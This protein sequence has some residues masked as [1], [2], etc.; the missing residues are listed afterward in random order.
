M[1]KLMHL[2]EEKTMSSNF[3]FLKEKVEYKL[4]A[5]AAIDAENA[6]MSVSA[7]MSASGARK[8][9][10]LGVKWVYSADNTMTEPYSDNLQSLIQEPSF[11]FAVDKQVWQKFRFIIKLGNRAIHTGAEV[12]REDAVFSLLGLF[13]FIQWIDCCYGVDYKERVFNEALIPKGKQVEQETILKEKE[14]L[15]QEREAEIKELREIIAAKSKT[16]TESKEGH[17]KTRSFVATNISEYETRKRF[18]DIDLKELGWTLGSADNENADARIEVPLVGMPYDS[19]VG[20]ADYVLYGKDGLPLAVVEAKK[21]SIDPIAGKTQGQLYAKCLEE[22]TGQRPIIFLTNGFETQIWDDTSFPPR[23][24]SGVFS[25]NDLIKLITRRTQK[26]E[27]RFI[28]ISDKIT[29]RYYQKEA[30]RA[31]CESMEN[32]HRKSLLVMATGT[33]KTRTAASLVDVLSRGNH[34]TNV[35]FLA[36]RREL[37]KQAKDSFRTYLPDMSLCNLLVSRDDKSA[38]I[39]FSTYP[40][41]LNAID[42]A[43]NAEN[44]TLFTPAHFD[45]IIIDEA[46]RSIFKKYRAIFEYFDA[47]LV[48]LTATPKQDVDRNTYEFFDLKNGI[49]TFAYDYE[50]ARDKDKVLVRYDAIEVNTE[51]L[52]D[53]IRYEKL[54]DEDKQRYEDDF[55]DEDGDMPDYIPPPQ[56]N[57]FVFNKD[58]VDLVL[59]MLMEKGQRIPGKD[60]PGKTIIFATNQKHAEFIE[61]RFNILYPQYKGELAQAITN[62]IQNN[63]ELI[64]TFKVHDKNPVI[65]ISV[66]M[67]DTGLDVPEILNLVFFKKVMSKTKFWQMI[68]RGTRLSKDL[69]GEGKDKESFYIFDFLRNFAYFGE[70]PKGIEAKETK[71]TSEAIFSKKVK[72]IYLL[73]DADFMDEKYQKFRSELVDGIVTQ[74]QALN[75]EQVAVRLQRQH[76]EKYKHAETFIAI[77]EKEDALIK[78][79]APLI[80]TEEQ[81]ENAKRF[82]D[83]MYGLMV[84]VIEKSQKFNAGKK[85]LIRDAN[86]LS[87]E[88]A[89]VSDVK[90]KI[91]LI[92]AIQ[93]DAFWEN[94]DILTLENIRIQ[95]RGVMYLIVEEGRGLVYTDLTDTLISASPIG[96]QPKGYEY[97][98]YKAKVNR[99]IEENKNHLAIHKLRNNLPLSDGEYKDLE[100]IFLGELGTKEDYERTFGETPLGL[101]VR[102]V[103]K[104]EAEAVNV[105]FSEFINDQNLNQNQ[106][107]F[108]RKIIDYVA[109]NGYV[110]NHSSLLKPPFDKPASFVKLFDD[111]K[112]KRIFELLDQVKNNAIAA[113]H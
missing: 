14:S 3:G 80:F 69:L 8:A 28:P 2:S 96:E 113:N 76:I 71:S 59:Q 61:E 109:Q 103:A 11:K 39:V 110:E 50:T 15:L 25:K 44:E 17:K 29:D 93:T 26:K 6:L 67:L 86:K 79:L 42:T 73:Q 81:D 106:I 108:V 47:Y 83:F 49:P 20:V 53:G 52:D 90:E 98:D 55:G 102:Q 105:A 51:F 58:T 36:D 45:L 82:D 78:H 46:H 24:V 31:I 34:I 9:L 16:Y 111:K 101:L 23:K 70:N 18:I 10:E 43:K 57:K 92:K 60:Y 97:G 56:I 54:S 104:M 91:E 63:S 84:T 107:V 94:I 35:L 62:K 13:E 99:Y 33:G 77:G 27:L 40:T 19:G 87:S 66:D 21:T 68:G 48:G 41:I 88:K 72:L 74:I 4:F 38:R 75:P 12:S 85:R 112:Q 32:G 7:E 89:T 1:K 100:R 30:I 65:A 95:L 22:M 64:A 5:D 37:V